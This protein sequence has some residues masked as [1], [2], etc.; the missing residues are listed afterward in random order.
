MNRLHTLSSDLV[1]KL[2]RASTAKQRAAGVAAGEL[3]VAKAKVEHPLVAEAL[4]QLRAGH[5]FTPREKAEVD[6]LVAQLD[7]EYFNLQDAADAGRADANDYLRAFAKARA[8]AALSFAGSDAPEA[9]ADSI[10]EAAAAMGDDKAEL[11]SLIE[12]V[13]K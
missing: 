8:I 3:A 10:Y 6:A 4:R 5:V 9:A 13:L 11:F 2:R 1:V 7:E 12:S